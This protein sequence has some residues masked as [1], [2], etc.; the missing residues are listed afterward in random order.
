MYESS[1]GNV[2][3]E[4]G[5]SNYVTK[6]S[7]KGTTGIDTSALGSKADLASLKT[8]NGDLDVDKLKTVHADLN[9]LEVDLGL[10]QHPRWSA[11]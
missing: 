6:A 11:L 5:L 4:L 8:K 3:V 1:G 2:K 10:L 7:L 9:K